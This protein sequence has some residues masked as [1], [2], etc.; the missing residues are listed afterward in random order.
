MT[1]S[2]VRNPNNVLSLN[3][4][5]IIRSLIIYPIIGK[6]PSLLFETSIIKK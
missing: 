4:S 5:F 2:N 6:I 1:V 3:Y